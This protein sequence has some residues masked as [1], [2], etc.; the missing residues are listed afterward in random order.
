MLKVFKN[1][2]QYE[3]S[4]LINYEFEKIKQV[5]NKHV[6]K[7]KNL[8]LANFSNLSHNDSIIY[9]YTN[10]SG[11]TSIIDMSSQN[12]SCIYIFVLI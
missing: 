11:K 12:C 7:A 8:I 6:K 4:K 1:V 10:S 5:D 9:K 3:S 2:I